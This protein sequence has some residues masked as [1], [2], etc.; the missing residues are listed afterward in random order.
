MSGTDICK[1]CGARGYIS[2][3]KG[4]HLRSFND[5]HAGISFLYT[6]KEEELNEAKEMLHFSYVLDVIPTSNGGWF[7]IKR[8]MTV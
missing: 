5:S 6:E 2:S 8:R 3:D 4:S 7:L 1:C